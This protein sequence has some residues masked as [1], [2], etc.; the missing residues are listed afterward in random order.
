M[1]VK[2]TLGIPRVPF[3]ANRHQGDTVRHQQAVLSSSGR[4]KRGMSPAP[5]LADLLVL[6]GRLIWSMKA[7]RAQSL[8]HSGFGPLARGKCLL[9][10]KQRHRVA[11]QPDQYPAGIQCLHP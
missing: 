6:P 3:P 10:L 4:C 5:N 1:W 2:M 9:S 11:T 8:S 7:N